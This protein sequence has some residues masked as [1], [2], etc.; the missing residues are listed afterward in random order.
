[1][2][3]GTH[4][5]LH[6]DLACRR[7]LTSSVG[8]SRGTGQATGYGGKGSDQPVMVQ[9]RCTAPGGR[10]EVG[11][12]RPGHNF[13]PEG[14]G[15]SATECPW[16]LHTQPLEAAAAAARGPAWGTSWDLPLWPRSRHG[17]DGVVPLGGSVLSCA[18]GALRAGGAGGEAGLATPDAQAREWR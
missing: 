3:P 17:S 12:Q 10:A 5:G 13:S 7:L 18:P 1:M 14:W 6:G 9:S 11:K 2:R 4:T 8:S 16:R 15:A